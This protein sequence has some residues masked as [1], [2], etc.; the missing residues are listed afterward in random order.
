MR[1]LGNLLGSRQSVDRS[2]SDL[3]VAGHFPYGHDGVFSS[4]GLHSLG[5]LDGR[6]RQHSTK[7]SSLFLYF[8]IIN[9]HPLFAHTEAVSNKYRFKKYFEIA[10]FSELP[11]CDVWQGYLGAIIRRRHVDIR[12]PNLQR[13]HL[14]PGRK[15]QIPRRLAQSAALHHPC[16]N[17]L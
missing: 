12:P 2:L 17:P 6:K 10:L 3:E 15:A 14:N 7:F 13:P 8:K 16:R 9:M 4:A 1:H 5:Q 11:H